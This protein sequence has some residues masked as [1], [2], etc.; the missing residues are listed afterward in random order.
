MISTVQTVIN[1]PNEIFTLPQETL[2]IELSGATDKT[3]QLFLKAIEQGDFFNKLNKE[4]KS[5]LT[6]KVMCVAPKH[7]THEMLASFRNK[8]LD[9]KVMPP[10]ELVKISFA[11]NQEFVMEKAREY[12][13]KKFNVDEVEDSTLLLYMLHEDFSKFDGKNFDV[14]IEGDI[15]IDVKVDGSDL[16][17]IGCKFCNKNQFEAILSVYQSK[18]NKFAF[19]KLLEERGEEIVKKLAEKGSYLREEAIGR[20]GLLQV[21]IEKC[22]S[23]N[24]DL[25]PVF[26]KVSLLN[27]PDM[28]A[29]AIFDLSE[30]VQKKAY[31]NLGVSL[32]VEFA[33]KRSEEELMM[34]ISKMK[35]LGVDPTSILPKRLKKSFTYLEKFL[36]MIG[37]REACLK[38]IKVTGSLSE[39]TMIVPTEEQ[40]YRNYPRK[41]ADE[42]LREQIRNIELEFRNVDE[43]IWQ[44]EEFLSKYNQVMEQAFIDTIFLIRDAWEKSEHVPMIMGELMKDQSLGEDGYVYRFFYD[45]FIEMYHL[46]RGYGLIENKSYMFPAISSED[47]VPYFIPSKCQYHWRQMF[48]VVGSLFNHYEV[49]SDSR[50]HTWTW[51]DFE[52]KVPAGT[53]KMIGFPDTRPS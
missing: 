52:P 25:K 13:C 26:Q 10:E 16:L 36:L 8:M 15:A 39:N 14:F 35:N 30:E 33:I 50:Y 5:N 23:L 6:V 7:I 12:Y 24:I 44:N 37:E 17:F 34:L 46:A 32:I 21:F 20:G 45:N 18:M 1:N 22:R 27:Q 40:V 51:P 28:I 4:E 29:F 9:S 53:K 38:L 11:A 42:N 31:Q 43:A 19:K 41:L 2:K 48:L 49:R 47:E 3:I